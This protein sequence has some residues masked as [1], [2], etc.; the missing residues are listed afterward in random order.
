MKS[1]RNS[2]WVFSEVRFDDHATFVSVERLDSIR[3]MKIKQTDIGTAHSNDDVHE[4]ILM[5]VPD[6]LEL[7]LE[8]IIEN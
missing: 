6:H 2:S 1:A 4:E 8:Y 5:E 7:I 3:D